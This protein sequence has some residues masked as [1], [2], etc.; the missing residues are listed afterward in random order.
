MT[1]F[2]P[3]DGRIPMGAVQR[4]FNGE[5]AMQKVILAIAMA[6]WLG[7]GCATSPSS[8]LATHVD[9][10][11]GLRTDLLSDN[12]LDTGDEPRE[13]VWLNA[14]RV[15]ESDR[16]YIYYLEVTYMAREEVGL[17]DINPGPSLTLIIDGETLAVSGSGSLAP[18]KKSKDNLVQET[19]IYKV[20]KILLQKIAIGRNVKVAIQ[21]RHGLVE[22]QLTQENIDKFQRFV[23]RYAL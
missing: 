3:L 8:D 23:T 15:F 21:G 7:A 6:G 9:Q 11:S 10:F 5:S 20:S 17:L 18:G 19:A 1:A 22:R 13:L 4:T 16:K 12:L 14:S 2:R